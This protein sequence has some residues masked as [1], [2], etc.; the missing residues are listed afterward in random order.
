MKKA[1]KIAGKFFN[2]LAKSIGYLILVGLVFGA[3]FWFV[4]RPI[5][6]ANYQPVT[7]EH[8]QQKETYLAAITQ[9]DQNQ[10]NI[11]L[12]NFDDLGYG[13]LS[14][15][16]NQLIKTP[17]IDS[18]AANGVRM[19]AFYSCSPVCT[20]S[21]AGLL[22]GRF[23]IQAHA[24][25]SVFFPEQH[26]IADSRKFNNQANEL[27]KDEIT[28]AEVLK[29]AGYKTG[30]VGKWHLGDRT[31]HLPNDFGFDEYYGVHYSNDMIPLHIYRNDKIEIEDK[32]ELADGEGNFITGKS[33][34]RD[35]EIPLKTKGIDQ[36]S[37]TENYTKEAIRFI[38]KNKTT[39]FFLYFAH[40]FP[41]V[42]HFASKKH[43]GQ[44]DGGV[45]G[46][47]IEDLDR[48]VAV[49]IETL[50]RLKLDENTL[51]II[52]SDNGAD[53]N[54]SVGDLRGRKTQTYEGGQKVPLIAYWKGTLTKNIVT[55]QMAMNTDL[56]PTLLSIV[57]VPLPTDRK[58]DGQNIWSVWK[59]N[60]ESP[61]RVLY[62]FSS[63]NGMPRGARDKQ[64]KYHNDAYKVSA[65][66]FESMA[67][68]ENKKPQL[69]NI[70][71]DNESHNL[72]EKYPE[73]AEQ[74]KVSMEQLQ[75]DLKSNQRGWIE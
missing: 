11:I 51:M 33:S 8:L 26:P 68:T 29:A 67:V 52:T 43:Q 69:T 54:G 9:S 15:Y 46:D 37:L 50:E 18:L 65:R 34:Y 6:I 7:P 20:P 56:F 73:V 36:T 74:L 66:L 19:T 1:F 5:K 31:G 57:Q 55:D 38:T 17:A 44:S 72:I 24:G 22:T 13:D 14:C 62:Y 53:F 39:P 59:D 23:P 25:N 64:F 71:L 48:S 49:I 3:I 58:I 12:I 41:H 30:M 35:H 27:P 60:A 42:P 32:T 45:Y 61:H 28:I 63:G 47:V 10:P 2:I 40:S 4:W 21:R 75:D 70:L 16:G